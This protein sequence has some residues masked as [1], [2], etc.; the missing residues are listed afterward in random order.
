MKYTPALILL[1]TA[2]YTAFAQSDEWISW[3]TYNN[4]NDV[5]YDCDYIWV[6]TSSA[7]ITFNKNT[8]EQEFISESN[9]D[10]S[11]FIYDIEIDQDGNKWITSS[12]G[13]F[14]LKN[15][16]I[17]RIESEIID[18]VVEN[19]Y[20]LYNLKIDN[21]GNIWFSNNRYNIYKYNPT[22]NNCTVFSLPSSYSTIILT[23]ND[24]GKVYA[25][26]LNYTHGYYLYELNENVTLIATLDQ[27]PFKSKYPESFV[28]DSENNFWII[29]PAEVTY[30]KDEEELLEGG[31]IVYTNNRWHTFDIAQLN[32]PS[33]EAGYIS[34][35]KS[36]SGGIILQ[37]QSSHLAVNQT[38]YAHF[39]KFNPSIE[40]EL[41][42]DSIKPKALVGIDL[43][44]NIYFEQKDLIKI[45]SAGSKDTIALTQNQQEE[46]SDIYVGNDNAFWL[47]K[48]GKLGLLQNGLFTSYDDKINIF[49]SGY[50]L[51]VICDSINTWFVFND[52][53]IRFDEVSWQY[54]SISELGLNDFIS[55]I[56]DVQIDKQQNL[57]VLGNNLLLRQNGLSWDIMYEFNNAE[58]IFYDFIISDSIVYVVGDEHLYVYDQG[59][60]HSKL[61]GEDGLPDLGWDITCLAGQNGS[62]FLS[63]YDTIY[64]CSGIDVN[65]YLDVKTNIYTYNK[66][67][68]TFSW[69][70]GNTF[71]QLDQLNQLNSMP[72]IFNNFLHK[73]I[74]ADALGN[75]VFLGHYSNPIL[76]FNPNGIIGYSEEIV[77]TEDIP[78]ANCGVYINEMQDLEIKVFPNPS[79]NY[80]DVY[81]NMA[82][83]GDINI[84]IYDITGKLMSDDYKSAVEVGVILLNY[85]VSYYTSGVYFIHVEANNQT[86]TIPFIRL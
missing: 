4:V 36:Q 13:L 71:F 48:S 28:I 7:V 9:S 23:T 33:N 73:K 52:T 37:D 76:L 77:Q 12:N 11:G 67:T 22:I 61:W 16:I 39:D 68:Q 81:W 58:H 20:S 49:N 17:L 44:N 86:S 57:W 32:T 45:N 10:V 56:Q 26:A 40:F 74:G 72:V 64:R 50:L 42:S 83:S 51:N 55:K 3:Q 70:I 82:N 54:Y 75:I 27:L 43:E 34:A 80:I 47:Y 85:D 63:D 38:Y 30:G 24:V 79:T 25:V 15:N 65:I 78:L 31:I 46:Y 84:S 18:N 8:G 41:F 21:E 69:I 29:I 35:F 59:V 1:L 6:T 66:V 60:W 53:I 19:K 62:M 5:A 14:F 2:Y